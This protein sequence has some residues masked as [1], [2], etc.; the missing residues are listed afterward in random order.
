M[1]YLSMNCLYILAELLERN[2]ET[3]LYMIFKYFK[4]QILKLRAFSYI[5]TLKKINNKPLMSLI[6]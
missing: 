6:S 4:L 5:I 2:L 3:I 1:M